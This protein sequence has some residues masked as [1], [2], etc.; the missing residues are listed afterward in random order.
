MARAPL[1]TV[2]DEG[3]AWIVRDAL[4][5]GGVTVQVEPAGAE[6][7]YAVNALA[8]PMRV[9]VPAEQLDRA[10]SLLAAL[11]EEIGN[12]DKQLSAEA[13]AAGHGQ[14]AAVPGPPRSGFWFLYFLTLVVVILLGAIG[15]LT[16][17]HRVESLGL[18]EA[19]SWPFW[20]A[21]ATAWA[22]LALVLTHL[23]GRR[24]VGRT[25]LLN[26]VAALLA[27]AIA[28]LLLQGH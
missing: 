24:R 7:P 11:E 6:H 3:A 17:P 22:A 27:A 8:R 15:Y 9:W 2:P 1:V 16:D 5:A 12:D 23:F 18:G 13:M 19:R 4:T 25:A 20:S 14:A 10:R 28:F 26:V 21:W